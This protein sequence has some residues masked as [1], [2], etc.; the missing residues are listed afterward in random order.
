MID[1]L[2]ASVGT[3]EIVIMMIDTR[4]FPR[5]GRF[6]VAQPSETGLLTE[7]LRNKSGIRRSLIP[8]VS[9][10]AQSARTD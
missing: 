4:S 7:V 5:P 9:F 10:A 8:M 3:T 1:A 2:L 6:D